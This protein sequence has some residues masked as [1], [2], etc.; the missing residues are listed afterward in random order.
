MSLTSI[1]QM[2]A[3]WYNISA[4]ILFVAER[5]VCELQE[6]KDTFKMKIKDLII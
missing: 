4:T 6:K 5:L 1:L 3:S 2:K